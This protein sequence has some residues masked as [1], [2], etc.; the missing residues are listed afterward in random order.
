MRGGVPTWMSPRFYK[1]GDH[2]EGGIVAYL[3]QSGDPGYEPGKLHGLIAYTGDIG[4]AEWG[5]YRE[6]AGNLGTAIG[7]GKSNTE[8]IAAKCGNGSAAAQCKT[9]SANGYADWYLPSLDELKKVYANRATIGGFNKGEYWTSSETGIWAAYMIRFLDKP[10][11]IDL[12]KFAKFH[13][14]PVRSF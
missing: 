6:L 9:F 12:S 3:L 14:R 1:V 10:D 13:V 4:D 7:T 8:A 2:A 11:Y 5:C